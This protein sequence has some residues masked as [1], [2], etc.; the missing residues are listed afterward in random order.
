M[1]LWYSESFQVYEQKQNGIIYIF[2]NVSVAFLNPLI[3][4]YLK[5]M[6]RFCQLAYMSNRLV[7]F[8]LKI[9]S[10]TELT[11]ETIVPC[12]LGT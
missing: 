8:S 7:L 12:R 5:S 9:S 1:D 10:D 3:T 6:Q 4:G 11:N 2:L